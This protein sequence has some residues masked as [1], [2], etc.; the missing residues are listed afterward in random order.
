ML[1]N[2]PTSVEN[3]CIILLSHIMY[4]CRDSFDAYLK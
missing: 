2:P 4:I 3:E 1:G